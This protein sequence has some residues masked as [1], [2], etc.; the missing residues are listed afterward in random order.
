MRVQIPLRAL[1][2]HIKE[3]KLMGSWDVT[4]MASR[5]GISAGEKVIAV[6]LAEN[7]YS[8]FYG[9]PDG[10]WAPLPFITY[11]EYNDYGALENISGRHLEALLDYVEKHVVE[12]DWGKNKYHDIPVNPH[13]ITP[14]YMYEADHEG[15]LWL[16]P[17]TWRL[18]FPHIGPRP[19]RARLKVAFIRQSL[20]DYIIEYY[21]LEG[22][23]YDKSWS[24]FELCESL[25]K[26]IPL[27]RSR[28]IVSFSSS[29]DEKIKKAFLSLDFRDGET[30]PWDDRESYP[31]L[32]FME[33]Y[34]KPFSYGS[35]PEPERFMA[36]LLDK[37]DHEFYL[38]C[39]EHLK[40]AWIKSFLACGRVNWCPNSTGPQISSHSFKENKMLANYILEEVTK[41]EKEYEDDN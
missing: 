17:P 8:D 36:T 29:D 39:I 35:M 14:D 23:K 21:K 11:G 26:E 20:V 33:S 1:Y 6:W 32:G 5:V 19:D 25:K 9:Y 38:D 40:F 3:E 7:V 22:W 12:I 27:L 28:K 24:Y 10:F 13:L 31:A 16:K 4:C 34:L 30:I 18:N 15:R 37:T 2:N 41:L